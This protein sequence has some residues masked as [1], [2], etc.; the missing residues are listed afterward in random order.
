MLS[1]VMLARAGERAALVAATEQE[2]GLPADRLAAAI[3][4]ACR[5]RRAPTQYD[6]A[7][8]DLAA[9]AL[10]DAGQDLPAET[11]LAALDA[12]VL[13]LPA[14]A[15]G[16][17][18]PRAIATVRARLRR[19]LGRFG[20]GSIADA[21]LT[22]RTG[23]GGW[24]PMP[25]MMD[26]LTQNLADTAPG[27]Q[28]LE[29]IREERRKMGHTNILIA[30]RTGVGKSSLINAVFQDRLS[31]A[32]ETG[33]GR[34]VTQAIRWYEAEGVT[35]RLCDTR[36]LELKEYQ[37][38]LEDLRAEIVRGRESP[39]LDRQLHL[40]WLCIDEPSARVQE[41]ETALATLCAEHRLPL[42]V[43]LTKAIG[44]RNFK[45]TVAREMPSARAVV[46]VLA[47]DWEDGAPKAFGIPDLLAATR[48]CLDEAHQAAFDAATKWD[49]ALKVRRAMKTVYA[50]AGTAGAGGAVPIPL[51][52]AAAVFGIQV[53]MVARVAAQMGVALDTDAIK[54]LAVTVVSALALT[55][56]GRYLA[57]QLIKLIPGIGSV[58][59]GAITGS[60]AAATTYGL[61]SAFVTYLEQFFLQN[62]RMPDASE[63]A[64]GFDRFWQG[65]ERKEAPPTA[66]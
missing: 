38:T 17:A 48:D 11:T 53:G 65:W 10:Q 24:W 37:R 8:A 14:D 30:G 25:D 57:G 20:A 36:G 29:T 66:P 22:R 12:L 50:A 23:R 61:G 31:V 42:V 27:R 56:G 34:P 19:D 44:P 4:A 62:K 33:V 28:V 45:D 9:A 26:W 40:V 43:V 47:Q 39:T 21:P 46:R 41:G 52:D 1:L 54:P 58:V 13:A 59:G 64:S 16:A 60:V 15:P 18:L 5:E 55:T 2:A 32:A 6:D 35:V 7:A 51:A 3:E 49:I 63:L